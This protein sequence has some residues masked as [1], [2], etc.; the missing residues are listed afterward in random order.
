MC[1]SIESSPLAR[2]LG[3]AETDS[4]APNQLIHFLPLAATRH[5]DI[6]YLARDLYDRVPRQ[7]R[8]TDSVTA[9]NPAWFHFPAFTLCPESPP[10]PHLTL[11]WPIKSFDMFGSWRWVHAAYGYSSIQQ[12]V[13]VFVADAEGENWQVKVIRDADPASWTHRVDAIWRFL[14]SFAQAS[15]IEWRLSVCR[16]S[17][18]DEA[19]LHGQ[20]SSY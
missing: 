15:A 17:L 11:H 14:R 3:L 5:R 16:L 18:M 2:Y 19:E 10:K 7:I 1:N 6:Q 20:S 4:L 8:P 9:G 13:I 12:A